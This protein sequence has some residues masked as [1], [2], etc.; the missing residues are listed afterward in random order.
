M[1]RNADFL[2]RS[3]AG[4]NVLIK[5]GSDAMDFTGIITLNDAGKFLWDSLES[6]TDIDTLAEL[7]IDKYGIDKETALSDV[8]DFIENLR[9]NGCI[10]E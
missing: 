3:L 8:S 2:Y 1:K 7:L 10:D 6:D 4:Q 5:V 9:E